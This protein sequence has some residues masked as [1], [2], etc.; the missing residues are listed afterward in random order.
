MAKEFSLWGKSLKEMKELSTEEFAR[1]ASSRMRR[2]L[3][4][5]FDKPLMK[6]IEKALKAK[7][8]GK[9][10]A[11]IRTHKRDTVITPKFAG[12]KFAVYNGHEF[13]MFEVKP[14]MIGH[15]LGEFAMTRKRIVHGK[16][17]IGATRSSTAVTA[18]G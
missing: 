9:E 11:A 10:P 18:R 5:H 12:L 6:R 7:E 2:S 15:M 16:A 3:K 17:G 4:R 8:A 1:L 14:E 13:P